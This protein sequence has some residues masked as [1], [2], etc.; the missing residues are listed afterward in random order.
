MKIKS[1]CEVILKIFWNI[2][3]SKNVVI[4]QLEPPKIEHDI[5]DN[6]ADLTD[7]EAVA[8]EVHV[9]VVFSGDR[10]GFWHGHH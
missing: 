7:I 2:W 4:P 9:E 8:A 5:A 3:K 10:D 6:S 1:D